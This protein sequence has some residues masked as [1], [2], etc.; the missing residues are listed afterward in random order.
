MF[1]P[2]MLAPEIRVFYANIGNCLVFKVLLGLRDEN[3]AIVTATFH[4]LAN[5][6]PILGGAVVVGAERGRFFV[7]QSPKVSPM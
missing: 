5:L 7:D 3:D 1:A 2:R 6:V 4:G